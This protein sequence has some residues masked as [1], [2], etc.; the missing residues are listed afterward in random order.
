MIIVIPA[1]M[2]AGIATQSA[3]NSKLKTVV[4]S[5]YLASTFS[6]FVGWLFLSILNGISHQPFGIDLTLLTT[7]PWWIWIGGFTAA[8]ALTTNVLLFP[9]LGSVQT[10]VLPIVGQIIVSVII[11]QFGLF[12]SPQSNLSVIKLLGI[13]ALVLGMLLATGGLK[14][15]TNFEKN[16]QHKNSKL[17]WQLLGVVAGGLLSVQS[18]VNGRLGVV[19]KSPIHAAAL[20]FLVAFIVVLVISVKSANSIKQQ[21]ILGFGAPRQDWWILCGGLLGSS[22]VALSAWLVPILGTGKVIIIALFGQ[23]LCSALIDQFGWFKANMKRIERLQIVGLLVMLVGIVL[24][25]L[26]A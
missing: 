13:G 25:Q 1:L 17:F 16:S 11:D 22:Y 21:I 2:G 15:K 4:Q 6:F 9:I 3:I 10:S 8:F 5:P 26:A 18:A 20:S 7:Q 19:L 12:H 23:L 24:V 14:K